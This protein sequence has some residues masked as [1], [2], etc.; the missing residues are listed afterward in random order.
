LEDVEGRQ[1]GMKLEETEHSV[2]GGDWDV[3]VELDNSFIN[4]IGGLN[5][6]EVIQVRD[7]ELE[8]SPLGMEYNNFQYIT[9]SQGKGGQWLGIEFGRVGWC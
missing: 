8:L 1:K 3:K 2:D 9:E 7:E 6:E 5:F 4:I